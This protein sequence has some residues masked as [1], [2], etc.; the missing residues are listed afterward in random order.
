MAYILKLMQICFSDI[1]HIWYEITQN[2][3]YQA[4]NGTIAILYWA[5]YQKYSETD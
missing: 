1:G 5:Q 2:L 3:Y 4:K